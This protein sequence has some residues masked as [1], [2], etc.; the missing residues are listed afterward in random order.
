MRSLLIFWSVSVLLLCVSLYGMPN[1][2]LAE[3]NYEEMTHGFLTLSHCLMSVDEHCWRQG[4]LLRV[5]LVWWGLL[6]LS[7]YNISKLACNAKLK[8]WI[9]KNIKITVEPS[10]HTL[11]NCLWNKE[12]HIGILYVKIQLQS[13][14]S[15][16]NPVMTHF[17]TFYSSFN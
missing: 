14:Q 15:F 16:Q 4:T 3:N 10:S 6:F 7:T 13:R 17:L 1:Q 9:V 11:E 5:T 12:N 2:T 8:D